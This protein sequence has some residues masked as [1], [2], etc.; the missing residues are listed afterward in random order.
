ME[1]KN[2]TFIPIRWRVKTR[3][4]FPYSGWGVTN[5]A[6]EERRVRKYYETN[7]L[8]LLVLLGNRMLFVIDRILNNGILSFTL[9]DVSSDFPLTPRCSTGKTPPWPNP[10]I[11]PSILSNF[12]VRRNSIFSKLCYEVSA[13]CAFTKKYTPSPAMKN[14]LPHFLWKMSYGRWFEAFLKIMLWIQCG[15]CFFKIFKI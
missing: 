4:L 3:K 7:P 9:Y 15:L 12:P 2:L 8:A 11:P 5:G 10:K 14:P 1:V 13:V 6:F